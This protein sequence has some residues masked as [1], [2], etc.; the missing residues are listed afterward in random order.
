MSLT[1]TPT[2][3]NA[4]RIWHPGNNSQKQLGLEPLPL[5]MSFGVPRLSPTTHHSGR[6]GSLLLI[7]LE[8]AILCATPAQA[9]SVVG[10]VTTVAGVPIPG[11]TVR[12]TSKLVSVTASTDASGNYTLG[13]T[14]SGTYVVVPTKSGYTFTPA[15]SNVTV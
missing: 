6:V 5:L 13:S 4:P 3:A 2:N 8:F 14:L 1:I 11:V 7:V 9:Q 12:G 10:Q 15:S